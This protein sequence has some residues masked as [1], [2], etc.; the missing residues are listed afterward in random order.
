MAETRAGEGGSAS[1]G[2]IQ[3]WTEA[4]A[5]TKPDIEHKHQAQ[6]AAVE[7]G[8]YVPVGAVSLLRLDADAIPL[9]FCFRAVRLP[10]EYTLRMSSRFAHTP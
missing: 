4:C 6:L 3:E 10:L 7:R 5:H 1:L 2:D 9:N 8:V